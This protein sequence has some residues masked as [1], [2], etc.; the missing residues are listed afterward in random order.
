MSQPSFYAIVPAHVRYCRDIEMGAKLLY[1]EITALCSQEGFCWA[2]N[3]YFADLY[4]VDISTIKRWVSSLKTCK[5]IKVEHK[6]EGIYEI[7]KIWISNE[8]QKM[9]T[10]AQKRAGGGSKMSWGGLK[11]EPHINTENITLNKNTPIIPKGDEREACGAVIRLSK[12]EYKKAEELCGSEV[13]KEIISE[14]NDY[15]LAHGKKYKDYLAAI[16]TWHR[17]RQKD[18]KKAKVDQ[19]QSN[20][21]WAKKII[22]TTNLK[23]KLEAYEEY[24]VFKGIGPTPDIVIK[25]SENGF[26]EQVINRLRKMGFNINISQYEKM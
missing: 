17:K 12:E 24:V 26:K 20:F 23:G 25:F 5:F 1:G 11:N 21:E 9:F 7:R 6:K 3:Q 22:N 2:T 18:P 16:R 19:S 13:L 4:D 8:I 14:M 10:A 15:L